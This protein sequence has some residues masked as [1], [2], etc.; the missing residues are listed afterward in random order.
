MGWGPR[1]CIFRCFQV[2]LTLLVLGTDCDKVKDFVFNSIITTRELFRNANSWA[3]PQNQKLVLTS[4]PGDLCSCWN[5][6]TTVMDDTWTSLIGRTDE[7]SEKGY[8]T[9]IEPEGGKTCPRG[10]P[11]K[12]SSTWA[13][14]QVLWTR[15]W[16]TPFMEPSVGAH[17]GEGAFL[18]F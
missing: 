13:L 16:T 7:L 1:F 9:S 10:Y 15:G 18:Q 4:H 11:V 6:R 3:L 2:M 14:E 17:S 12:P 5:S 8:S